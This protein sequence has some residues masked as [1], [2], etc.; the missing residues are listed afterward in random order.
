VDDETEGK[1][2]L[3]DN[4]RQHCE[5]LCD[6]ITESSTIQDLNNRLANVESSFSDLKKK[7]GT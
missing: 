6:L 5:R 3:V 2:S 1:K 7:L 4:A